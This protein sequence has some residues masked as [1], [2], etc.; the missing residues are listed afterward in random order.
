[1]RIDSCHDELDFLATQLLDAG[2]LSES[3]QT[4]LKELIAE[5]PA[6]LD[7]YIA[8]VALAND[9]H[10]VGASACVADT[11]SSEDGLDVDD[12]RKMLSIASGPEKQS[13]KKRSK[14]IRAAGVSLAVLAASLLV[15]ASIPSF[16]G[17]DDRASSIDRVPVPFDYV[18]TV[19]SQQEWEAEATTPVGCRVPTGGFTV[20]EGVVELQFDSGPSLLV[21]GPARIDIRSPSEAHLSL[22]KVVFRDETDG[23]PFRLT[24]PRSRFIDHGT[25]YAVA[26]TDED[27]EVHVFSG[28]VERTEGVANRD[29]SVD[30][31]TDGEA[32]RYS[33]NRQTPTEVLNVDPTMFVR[34]LPTPD[35]EPLQKLLAIETFDYEDDTVVIDVQAN[36]GAGWGSTWWPNGEKLPRHNADDVALR[37]DESLVFGGRDKASQGGSLGYVGEWLVHRPLSEDLSLARNDVRYV[38]F[39]FRP[40]ELWSSPENTVKLIFQNPDQGV[41]EHRIAVGIDIAR[42]HIRGELCGV[43]GQ[44]PLPMASNSTYLI[45]MKIVAAKENP[46]QLMIRVFQ[47]HEPIG[48]RESSSW[49]VTT[50]MSDSDDSFSLMSLYFNSTQEQR[51]DEIRIGSSWS[52]VTYPWWTT[53]T[54]EL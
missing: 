45:V 27:E 40:G 7:Q 44:S 42:G 22:G 2:T 43:L 41:L 48:E 37:L 23:L 54:S 49:T 24:T 4:R 1:M 8:T 11:G 13:A 47:P 51:I 17:G 18:A 36:G 20:N 52:S 30:L 10:D 21:E 33:R 12:L 3:Q 25:E 15:I 5:D 6:L 50:P 19:V 26:V 38:S 34:E 53:A 16:F 28:T 32:K 14:A 39:L 35:D 9:L 29:R 46:D 31:L